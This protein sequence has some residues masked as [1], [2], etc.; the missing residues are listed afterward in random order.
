M[1]KY[2]PD[3]GHTV[4]AIALLVSLVW[5]FNQWSRAIEADMRIDEYIDCTARH[6]ERC[7]Q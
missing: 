7:V 6:C 2:E 1:K 3:Y 4:L 5:G